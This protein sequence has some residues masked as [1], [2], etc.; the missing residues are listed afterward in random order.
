[1][2]NVQAC[3]ASPVL[4]SSHCVWSRFP[5]PL[6]PHPLLWTS[7]SLCKFSSFNYRCPGCHAHLAAVLLLWWLLCL[8]RSSSLT[9]ASFWTFPTGA[10]FI[11]RNSA[12]SPPAHPHL[13]SESWFF[14]TKVFPPLSFHKW[15]L[16]CLKA[17]WQED[18]K[19]GRVSICLFEPKSTGIKCSLLTYLW[20]SSTCKPWNQTEKASSPSHICPFTVKAVLLQGVSHLAANTALQSWDL[21]APPC[22]RRKR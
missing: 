5:I 9:R 15:R 2:L 13:L 7:S 22:T 14:H 16:G 11:Q 12:W 18:G 21:P 20:T 4:S 19:W 3:A 6:R 17:H 1:M 10:L 8:L